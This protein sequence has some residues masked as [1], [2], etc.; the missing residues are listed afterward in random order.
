[1][2]MCKT[3]VNYYTR[4]HLLQYL[5]LGVRTWCSLDCPSQTVFIL[6][7][8]NTLCKTKWTII[9]NKINPMSTVVLQ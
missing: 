4:K 1:M 6:F 2:A 8:L 3:Y 5:K 9:H 7:Y